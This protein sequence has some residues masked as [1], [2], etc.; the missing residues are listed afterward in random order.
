LLVNEVRA[1]PGARAG[2]E[3]T[4]ETA[5]EP[6]AGFCRGRTQ[7]GHHAPSGRTG[8]LRSY[9]NVGFGQAPER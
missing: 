1:I 8:W 2:I 5:K 3:L 4:L 6:A 7:C 9:A